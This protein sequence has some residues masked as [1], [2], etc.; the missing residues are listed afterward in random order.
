MRGSRTTRKMRQRR[1]RAN[2]CRRVG[3]RWGRGFGAEPLMKIRRRRRRDDDTVLLILRAGTTGG[4]AAKI[5]CDELAEFMGRLFDG[6]GNRRGDEVV[7]AVE[8]GNR[9]VD[10]RRALTVIAKPRPFS[11]VDVVDAVDE[12]GQMRRQRKLDS[13]FVDV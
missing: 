4:E 6:K 8:F 12:I 13:G 10:D 1:L 11:G 9:T 3:G 5:G 2:R 7:T